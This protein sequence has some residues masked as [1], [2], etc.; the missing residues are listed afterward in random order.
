MPK[1]LGPFSPTVLVLL[2]QW[3]GYILALTWDN[4]ELRTRHE[5]SR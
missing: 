1:N 2:G 3:G 4:R 5:G